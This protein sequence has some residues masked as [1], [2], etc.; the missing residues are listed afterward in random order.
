MASTFKRIASLYGDD[1][2]FRSDVAFCPK[3]NTG[4]LIGLELEGFIKRREVPSSALYRRVSYEGLTRPR[5]LGRSY[6]WESREIRTIPFDISCAKEVVERTYGELYLPNRKIVTSI[7]CGL[8]VH[9][10]SFKVCNRNTVKCWVDIREALMMGIVLAVGSH[11]KLDERMNNNL[12]RLLFGRVPNR[13]CRAIT[14]RRALLSFKQRS[15][16]WGDRY[17]TLNSLWDTFYQTHAYY[18]PNYEIRAFRAPDSIEELLMRVEVVRSLIDFVSRCSMREANLLG[19]INFILDNK[20]QYPLIQSVIANVM[21]SRY[22]TGRF[23]KKQLG[24]RRMA[25]YYEEVTLE[26]VTGRYLSGRYV[27]NALSGVEV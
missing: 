22:S 15:D 21:R 11:Q 10:S 8:H 24:I 4:S 9:I 14:Y 3:I 16:G 25:P 13:W 27:E 20:S 23:L 1:L 2:S 7:G 18:T 19:F 17:H 5:Y 12:F 6:E 26:S